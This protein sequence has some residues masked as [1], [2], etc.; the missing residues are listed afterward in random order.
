MLHP[1]ASR[2]V[3]YS[4]HKRFGFSLGPDSLEIIDAMDTGKK[5]NRSYSSTGE[6]VA[7]FGIEDYPD[8]V[9]WGSPPC[10]GHSG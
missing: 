7:R 9:R 2:P 3:F 10:Y 8:C 5:V 6:T 1:L 4:P